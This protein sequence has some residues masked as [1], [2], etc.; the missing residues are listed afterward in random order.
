LIGWHQDL[1]QSMLSDEQQAAVS[2]VL[3]TP[4][5]VTIRRL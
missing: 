4:D 1:A 2:H 5:R 3:T